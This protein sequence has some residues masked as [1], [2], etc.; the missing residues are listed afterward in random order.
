MKF[1]HGQKV[2]IVEGYY[3][4]YKGF[5]VE[6][7]EKKDKGIEYLINIKKLSTEDNIKSVWLP[8]KSLKVALF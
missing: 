8:E 4:T 1:H 6:A 3:K 5:I 7:Q 2:K